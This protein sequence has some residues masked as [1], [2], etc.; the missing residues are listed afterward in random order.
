MSVKKF[1]TT[2]GAELQAAGLIGDGKI[3]TWND[4]E[5][6]RRDGFTEEE[7]AA[8]DLVISS[9]DP[10]GSPTL[11]DLKADKKKGLNASC[12]AEI[13]G[14]FMSP[15]LGVE[16]TYPSSAI[17]QM[18]LVQSAANP[19]NSFLWVKG[20][21]GAWVFK[22]HTKDQSNKALEDFVLFRSGLQIKLSELIDTVD[23]SGTKA[24]V[25]A[26]SW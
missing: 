21:D 6:F 5:I 4:Y 3:I 8:L 7:S 11:K 2:F 20:E 26:I 17:D 10:T 14:G 1:G 18:N 16:N 19:A 15:A 9:H 23:A 12:D 22:P 24:E 13:T 25:T